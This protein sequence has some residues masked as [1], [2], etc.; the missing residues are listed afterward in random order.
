MKFFIN[1]IA[2]DTFGLTAVSLILQGLGIF[3]NALITQKLGTASVGVMTLIFTLFG[4][5][6]VL[7][8]GNIFISTS[9]FVSEEIGR[10]NRNVQR[11][12]RYSLSFSMVLSCSFTAASFLLADVLS[13]KFSDFTDISLPIR[14][15][16]LSLPFASA[17]S[18]IKGY[19]HAVRCVKVPCRGDC[20]EF[21]AKWTVLMFSVLFLLDKGIDIYC[22]IAVSILIGEAASFI[23]YLAVYIK[24][25]RIFSKFPSDMYG[26]SDVPRYLKM[27]LPILLSGYVQMIL[28]AANDALVPVALLN[29]NTSAER[30]MS[31]YGMFEAMIIPALF[32]PA[33][34]LSSLSNILMPEIARACSSSNSSR[35]KNLV[36]KALCSSF[37]YAFFVSGLFFMQGKNIGAV[38]CP[39][40]G[41]VGSTLTKLFPVVPFIYLEIVLESILKGMGK[42]NFSTVNSL[43][44]YA[45]RIFCVIFFVRLYGFVGVLISYY[46]SNIYSN[47]I[48]ILAVCRWTGLRF[49]LWH[50]FFKPA[51]YSAA[52]CIT[53]SAVCLLI[54]PCSPLLEAVIFI[55]SASIMFITVY[56]AG[57]FIS[58]DT[59]SYAVIISKV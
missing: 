27:C 3:L 35:L 52:S 59:S 51:A 2:R 41:L 31:E 4:F 40:D 16:A 55:C 56:E 29:Y 45:I 53:A 36:H 32:Y 34:I 48:R 33:V 1:K 17:G 25:Y 9:R 38:L 58:K 28:S 54:H 42:Q 46:A 30:A 18:C 7:A 21:F 19:F 15:I 22:M 24:E 23:Y 10:G 8:N 37:L 43:C 57:R 49:S 26:I 39:S 20:T 11:I 44:E 12:M 14:I 13:E 47:I 6:M 50:Y 5:I